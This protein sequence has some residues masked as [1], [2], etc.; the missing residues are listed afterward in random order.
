MVG[1]V[2][3]VI[4]SST[5]EELGDERPS[6]ARALVAKETYPKELTICIVDTIYKDD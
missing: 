4:V 3:R 5:G 2:L 6:S 1:G